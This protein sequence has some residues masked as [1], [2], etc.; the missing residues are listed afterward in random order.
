MGNVYH[1]VVIPKGE[2][3]VL[4]DGS[5]VAILEGGE[6]VDVHGADNAR[7]VLALLR[8]NTP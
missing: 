1:V 8:S 5:I 7:A 6:I 3:D 2:G 4:P